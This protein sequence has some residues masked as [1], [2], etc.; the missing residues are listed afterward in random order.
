MG[1]FWI[2]ASVLAALCQA[3]RYAALKELNAHLPAAVTGY[4]RIL[5][6][7]PLLLV[8]LA[9][10][11]FATETPMPRLEPWFLLLCC[12]CAIGQFLGTVLMIRL[13]QL[14][15][16]AVGTMLTK[17]DTIMTALIGSALFIEHITAMGWVAI[18]V[19]VAGVILI[20][21]A[22]VP[23]AAW[24]ASDIPLWR[25]VLS[26]ATQLGLLISLVNAI[27]YLVLREAISSVKSSGGSSVDAAVAGTVM[28]VCSCILLGGWLMATDRRGLIRIRRHIGLCSFIGLVSALGT[29]FWF[30]AAAVTNV[31]Y[32]AAVTQVQIVF[33]LLLSR[34]W[35]HEAIKPLELVGIAI[36]LAGVLLFRA[37]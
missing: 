32:V 8:Y 3:L 29:I 1:T 10:V 4:A 17:A 14:G 31:S 24:R 33:A 19:T 18:L 13:F 6:A 2:W 27:A 37:V 16:F 9:A 11:L 15:N 22:R 20:S 35:F 34:Y 36:I 5:F 26:P 30:L 21:T 25:V 28:T 23:V 7:T 12:L